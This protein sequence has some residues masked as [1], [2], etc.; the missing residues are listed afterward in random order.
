LLWLYRHGWEDPGLGQA[1]GPEKRWLA[2]SITNWRRE[3][4]DRE[5]RA[6]IRK[7]AG[8]A[9]QRFAKQMTEG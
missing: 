3:I 6:Q 7:A 4:E 1:G 2:S 8:K 5:L 9:W